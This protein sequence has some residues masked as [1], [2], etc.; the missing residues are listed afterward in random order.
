MNDSVYSTFDQKPFAALKG[1]KAL[2]KE[3]SLAVQGSL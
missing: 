1:G 3:W 2:M